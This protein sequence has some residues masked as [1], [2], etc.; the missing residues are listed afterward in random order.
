M[1]QVHLVSDRGRVVMGNG[2]GT[3]FSKKFIGLL[4]VIYIG[5][6]G[7]QIRN[8]LYKYIANLGGRIKIAQ[9][10]CQLFVQDIMEIQQYLQTT[11]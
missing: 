2:N 10:L 3:Y 5:T 8:H 7:L 9:S 6:I 1:Q 4:I 11:S